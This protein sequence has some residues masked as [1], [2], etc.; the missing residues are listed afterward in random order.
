MLYQVIYEYKNK[1]YY[2]EF[3]ANH[4]DNVVDF[5]N[6][7]SSANVL[8]IR[9]LIYENDNTSISFNDLKKSKMIFKLVNK[10]KQKRELLLPLVKSSSNYDVIISFVSKNFKSFSKKIDFIEK[11]HIF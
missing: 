11:K 3:E 6:T 10:D 1:K 5:L 7:V 9:E 2:D 4:F 8:E